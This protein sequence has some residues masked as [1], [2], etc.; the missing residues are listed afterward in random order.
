MKKYTLRNGLHVL[1]D[2]KNAETVSIMATVKIGSLYE[3]ANEGISH[4]VEHMVFEGTEKR[5]TAKDITSEIEAVGGMINA[6]TDHE[7]T[8]FFIKVPKKYFSLAVDILSDIMQNA[9][10]EEDVLNKEREVILREINMCYDEP[11]VHQ[12]LLFYHT[13]F[14]GHPAG[15]P[16][17]GSVESLKGTTRQHMRSFYNTYYVPNNM[18][19]GVV[20]NVKNAKQLIEK[21][22]SFNPASVPASA[23]PIP[24]STPS[25]KKINKK[26]LNA[27]FVLGY[28]T[29]SR[30]HT[31]SYALDVIQAILGRGQ[32]GRIFDE[33][34]NKRGLVYEV[35]VHHDTD[36]SFGVF[37]VYLNT[38]HKHVDLCRELIM[39]EIHALSNIS[40]KELQEAIGF[41]EGKTILD[42]ENTDKHVD[43]LCFWGLM[44][45]PEGIK[46]YLKNIK[47]ITKKDV[48]RVAQTYFSKKPTIALIE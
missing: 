43:D 22:F 21:K 31:D 30:D 11:R 1:I 40:E 20:G 13:L 34:R 4:F 37:S 35:G 29:V 12:W 45:K 23:I 10:F 26:I 39:K 46:E 48:A 44:G 38:E 42:H 5:K 33:I 16:I 18:I 41:I 17:F 6:Y 8:S 14:P 25:F 32:S 24:L 3:K 47:K 28:Q 27:Y 36:K 19:I 9:T 2:K 15:K 7:R